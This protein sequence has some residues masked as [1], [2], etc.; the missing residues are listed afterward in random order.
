MPSKCC[1]FHCRNYAKSPG[2]VSLYRFPKVKKNASEEKRG[3]LKT[4]RLAWCKAVRPKGITD[5]ELDGFR[6]C[7]DHFISGAYQI[8]LII[9]IVNK[10][11]EIIIHEFSIQANLPN[12]TT[13]IILTGN[14]N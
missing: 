13:S 3:L 2:G 9:E 4:Q 11:N 10:S 7:S 12:I 1:V 14:R 6:V 5:K 8:F